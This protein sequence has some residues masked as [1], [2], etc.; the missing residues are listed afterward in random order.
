MEL[1]W[2]LIAVGAIATLGAAQT[3]AQP[4]R[5]GTFNQQSIVVAFYRSP[6]WADRLKEKRAEGAAAK[7]ANDTK[8]VQ[9]L[10]DW[11]GG[12]QELAHRQLAGEAPIANILEALAPAFPGIAQKSQVAMIVADLPYASASVETVD[13]T[14]QLLDWLKADEATRKIVRD[15]RMSQAPQTKH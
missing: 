15:L 3:P 14:D 12:S 9:D 7:K 8:K 1:I 10:N 2:N 4:I 11:G 6:L 5:V 13:V